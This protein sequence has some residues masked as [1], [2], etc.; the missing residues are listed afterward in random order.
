LHRNPHMQHFFSSS[1][2]RGEKFQ[3][4]KKSFSHPFCPP[5]IRRAELLVR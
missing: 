3:R 2:R 4:G 1:F 5:F